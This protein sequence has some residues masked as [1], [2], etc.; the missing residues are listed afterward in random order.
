MAGGEENLRPLTY[1]TP[2]PMI[3][4]GG[5]P[6]LQRIIESFAQQGFGYHHISKL[7]ERTDYRFLEMAPN[8]I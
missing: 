8:G 7:F 6:I 3:K 1:K 4:I 2:K 5:V